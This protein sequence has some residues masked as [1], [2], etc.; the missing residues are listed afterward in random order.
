MS[1]FNGEVPG[2][3]FGMTIRTSADNSGRAVLGMN[4]L[5]PLERWDRGF[6]FHSRH[7]C[8]CVYSVFVFSCVGSGLASG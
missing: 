7:G 6:E 5:R 4:F 8:L 2:G 3:Y 1:Q